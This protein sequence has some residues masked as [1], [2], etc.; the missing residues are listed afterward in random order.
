MNILFSFRVP[1][2]K[3]C[4]VG[5]QSLKR[6]DA[7]WLLR[8]PGKYGD[9][10]SIG[11]CRSPNY[12]CPLHTTLL[13]IEGGK[14]VVVNDPVLAKKLFDDPRTCMYMYTVKED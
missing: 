5:Q 12:F 1:P 13:M 10:T 9:V 14:T 3:V 6:G 2:I 4:H 8:V 11:M 7:D